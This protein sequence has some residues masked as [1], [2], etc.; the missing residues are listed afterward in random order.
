MDQTGFWLLVGWTAAAVAIG[1]GLG[2]EATIGQYRGQAVERGYASYCPVD[3]EWAW[4]GECEEDP[5]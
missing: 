1:W 5:S 4:K 2:I 3:G